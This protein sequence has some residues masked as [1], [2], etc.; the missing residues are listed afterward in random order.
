MS[1]VIPN[2]LSIAGSDPSGG[3]GVQADLKVFSA[4]GCYGMA[5]VTALTAQN[6]RGVCGVHAVPAEF[7][8]AQL[9]AVF[10]DIRV[11]V[12]KIGMLGRADIVRVV[13]KI[14]QE[15][16]PRAVVLDPVMVATSGDSLMDEEAL[17]VLR[18]ELIPLV[19]V[20][21]PNKHEMQK[22]LGDDV[23]YCDKDGFFL[24]EEAV[25]P[26]LFV[27]NEM[28]YYASSLL[29]FGADVLLT[30]GHFRLYN[31]CVIDVFANKDGTLMFDVEH[32]DIGEMHG[33]GCS[34]SS[35]LA[36]Y[37]AHGNPAD[38]AVGMAQ[39][40]LSVAMLE[41]QGLDVGGGAMPLK[42]FGI[43]PSVDSDAWVDDLP[44]I[45]NNDN[46][47]GEFDLISKY[48]APLS[49]DGLT[50]DGAVLA[51]PDGM[52]M[53]VTTDTLNEGVH[54]KT[55][56]SSC[57]IASKSL[58]VSL[59]DLA[60][61]GA[62]PY[63]YQLSLSLPK[64][65]YDD[66]WYEAF[67]DT[68]LYLQEAF[69]VRLS[70]GDTTSNMGDELSVSI[71]A[72][73]LVPKGEAIG[74]D[75]AFDGDLIVVSGVI[76]DAVLGLDAVLKNDMGECSDDDWAQFVGRYTQP[77]PR[78]S[79]GKALRVYAHAMIDVSDGLVADVGHIAKASGLGAVIELDKVPLSE[80]ARSAGLD[81]MRAATGG[82]DYELAFA[83]APDDWSAVQSV[84]ASLNMPV[85]VIGAFKPG[86][87]VEV[88]DGDGE[89]VELSATGWT[90]F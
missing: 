16:K 73:G 17:Q 25:D 18:E 4:L 1:K 48:F 61:M 8:E 59:S 79:L 44:F 80:A 82:D 83:I 58:G 28:R 13:A 33:T 81:S 63:A 77:E 15:F 37:M 87:G 62:D 38:E 50:N 68:L 41:G 57:D 65:G 64:G 52:E 84:A 39:R 30:G 14:L 40:Y 46:H 67:A 31:G 3:A 55:C 21:T 78:L 74:R 6:T 23:R 86:K 32:L 75:G 56:S 20:V 22:L 7:V 19:S 24:A 54:F 42:H 71:T 60:S 90:H 35:A 88:L 51:V 27:L 12:V 5:V 70:G 76:G 66:D 11:D 2:I 43:S 47:V 72:F 69:G 9:R 34:F 53:V 85:T 89:S 26:D 36:C 49:M 10:T 29:E 45:R